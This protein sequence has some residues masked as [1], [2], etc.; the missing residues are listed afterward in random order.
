[1]SQN[2]NDFK[3]NVIE[4][5]KLN[6]DMT[7]NTRN[8]KL[9]AVMDSIS[10]VTIA[11][12]GLIQC[13]EL[14][15]W[16]L[17]QLT[18]R[19]QGPRWK[20]INEKSPNVEVTRNLLADLIKHRDPADLLL[21]CREDGQVRGVLSSSFT[22]Y[23]NAQL[24]SAI[25]HALSQNGMTEDVEVWRS[26]I[27]D[28]LR[29]FVMLPHS[30]GGNGAGPGGLR[31]GFHINNGET[32]GSATRLS[33]G[34]YRSSCENSLQVRTAESFRYVH[35]WH[36]SE[37][38]MALM[39][40]EG[41]VGAL[42]LSEEAAHKFLDLQAVSLRP[43]SIKTLMDEWSEKYSIT[44]KAQENW[45]ERVAGYTAFDLVNGLTEV[46]RDTE[47]VEVREDLEIAAG[48]LVY[49]EVWLNEYTEGGG[50]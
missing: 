12:L 19:L 46:A 3:D 10:V 6:F 31:P 8:I 34:L 5:S 2:W 35:R 39:V 37:T 1:M 16:A 36:Q 50:V 23:D 41:I 18:E 28:N 25:D 26:Q 33:G 40:N 4:W 47:S 13:G 27:G 44:V 43:S 14:T 38:H 11:D 9:D 17:G 29:A 45:L 15:D 48:D 42:K 21:R 49:A 30:I 24:V 32:G 20:W 22:P 7:E